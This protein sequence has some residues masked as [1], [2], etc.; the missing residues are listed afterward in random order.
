[1]TI[2]P[3]SRD[4]QLDRDGPQSAEQATAAIGSPPTVVIRNGALA[5]YDAVARRLYHAMVDSILPSKEVL[6][7]GNTCPAILVGRI[8][9]ST[10]TVSGAVPST[11]V[12]APGDVIDAEFG[13]VHA[14]PTRGYIIEPRDV[15]RIDRWARSK[16]WDVIGSIHCHADFWMK[17]EFAHIEIITDLLERR[18]RDGTVVTEM[19]TAF[20]LELFR[21][22]GWP[23][24]LV[25]FLGYEEGVLRAKMSAWCDVPGSS[26][27]YAQSQIVRGSIFPA[28]L[29]ASYSNVG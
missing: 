16:G 29:D 26:G 13:G 21:R 3:R 7:L 12:R 11:S 6:P 10:I 28:A 25:Y 15:L 17:P 27:A 14:D 23:L 2:A 18:R 24:N 22:T 9:G 19:P 5:E 20:D 8:S 4:S 1:M